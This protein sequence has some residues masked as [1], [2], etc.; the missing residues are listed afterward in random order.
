MMRLA[1]LACVIAILWFA[2]VPSD[3]GGLGG[4]GYHGIAFLALGLLTPI[5]FPRQGIF[6]IWLGLVALGGAIEVV[7]G[8]GD[9][10]RQADVEDW[11]IDIAAATVGIVYYRIG[12]YLLR[13]VK[14]E[15]QNDTEKEQVES[16]LDT[17]S[18]G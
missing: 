9:F 5:A 10:G 6:L 4:S 17:S 1:W 8:Y 2:L 3:L 11:F 15:K 16:T 18:G 14:A 7:Q 12:L 13:R